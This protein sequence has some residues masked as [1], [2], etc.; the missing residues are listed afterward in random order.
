MADEV[1]PRARLVKADAVAPETLF[2]A[3]TMS[4]EKAESI[5][6]SFEPGH[7]GTSNVIEDPSLTELAH[8]VMAGA[9]VPPYDLNVLAE[10]YD[11]SSCLRPN[12]D[13]WVTNID[14]Y[15][16]HLE[17]VIDFTKPGADEMVADVLRAHMIR[18]MSVPGSLVQFQDPTPQQIRDARTEI[19]ATM[20]QEKLRLESF[21][22][23]CN[24]E[25]SFV[26]L[27]RLMREEKLIMGNSYWE[28]L[29]NPLGGISQ[30]NYIPG[31]TVRMLPLDR[32][33]VVRT[34][35]IKGPDLEYRELTQEKY[36]RRYVQVFSTLAKPQA[37]SSGARVI[38]FK[39]FGDTRV[40]SKK[41][42]HIYDSVADL[43]RLD[44]TDAPA[45]EIIHFKS[46]NQR[47]P[48]GTPIW[49]GA[50]L[51]A[52]GTRQAEEV[53][54]LYFDNKAIPEFVVL[55]SGGQLTE[56]SVKT[57]QDF[58][59]SN[60]KGR[61]NFHK[62]LILE[63]EA[64]GTATGDS[65]MK[66]EIKPL[67]DAYLKDA[68]F[69]GYD[70]RNADK[71]G[72]MFRLPRLLRGD[73][74]DM[75][76]ATAM[77][78]LDYA[79]SQVFGPERDEFDFF[80]DRTFLAEMG[81]RYWK[82]V[83]NGP[84]MR[85]PERATNMF[86]K[87]AKWGALVPNEGRQIATEAFGHDFAPVDAPWAELPIGVHG[88]VQEKPGILHNQAPSAEQDELEALANEALAGVQ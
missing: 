62:G 65:R 55:V 44:P 51:A 29:R 59:A 15:G 9:I 38:F 1:A 16:H 85:D 78:A 41:T 81:I 70:E 14:G 30:I 4:V 48:Y 22:A 75:N 7:I 68:L 43:K 5:L 56:E 17:P 72:M 86:E 66:I 53:N 33:A 80:M 25:R 20:R 46:H 79:N 8:F 73:S 18:Q 12:V 26:A 69:M 13:A 54:F 58:I 88:V 24:A 82:F 47:Y 60:V 40:F 32:E 10:L 74:R 61:E 34:V 49:I 84:A 57:L 71:V 76:R 28:V 39:E 67:T 2:R 36:F 35:T 21:F 50:L 27:R 31:F 63:G 87:F 19:E 3:K 64:A 23:G 83:S 6:K 37:T 77:A 52:W 11:N 45:T 42:G